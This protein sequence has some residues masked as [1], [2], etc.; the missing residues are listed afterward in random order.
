MHIRGRPNEAMDLLAQD[1]GNVLG[2][3]DAKW[4]SVAWLVV[5]LSFAHEREAS[6]VLACDRGLSVEYRQRVPRTVDARELSTTNQRL[7]PLFPMPRS[8]NPIL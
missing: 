3:G 8:E 5:F 2:S 1:R 6:A 7:S 4:F